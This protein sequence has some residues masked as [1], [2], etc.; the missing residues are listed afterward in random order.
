MLSVFMV[1]RSGIG[2]LNKL[3]KWTINGCILKVIYVELD[4]ASRIRIF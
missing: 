1:S 4:K 2:Q 3:L